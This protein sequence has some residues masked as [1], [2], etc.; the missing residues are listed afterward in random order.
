MK[1]VGLRLKNLRESRN[2]SQTQMAELLN[3]RQPSINKY[4]HGA[5]TPTVENL[6]K[7]ADY[8]GVSMDYIFARTDEPTGKIYENKS[9]FSTEDKEVQQLVERCLHP[10]SPF[11]ARLKQLI[12]QM[13]IEI[14]G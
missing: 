3:L 10:D 11:H 5:A 1:A 12:V 8:F 6:R 7:Y 14:Q 13:L 9:Q 4:E 2:L